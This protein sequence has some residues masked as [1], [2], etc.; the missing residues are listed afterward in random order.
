MMA[1]LVPMVL[2]LLVGMS[3][4]V[5]NPEDMEALFHRTQRLLAAGDF[6]GARAG[7]ERLLAIPEQRLLRPSRV[8][9]QIDEE[10]VNLR[11]AARYQLANLER[12]QGKLLREE[13]ELAAPEAQDSLE[14]LAREHIRRA[15]AG[16]TDLKSGRALMAGTSP[17]GYRG[18]FRAVRRSCSRRRPRPP[19]APET[20][21]APWSLRSIRPRARRFVF[22]R[23][24]PRFASRYRS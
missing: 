11:D 2:A 12:R 7:Y 8:L 23:H 19:D 17:P 3:L 5:T 14:T 22:P 24:P 16:F 4:R 6:A 9:V 20:A 15:A 21:A 1:Y 18:S 10:A 13:K